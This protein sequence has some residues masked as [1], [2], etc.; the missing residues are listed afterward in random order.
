MKKDIKRAAEILRK[1]ISC[2]KIKYIKPL[3]QV[4]HKEHSKGLIFMFSEN[5]DGIFKNRAKIVLNE[6]TNPDKSR[7]TTQITEIRN[8]FK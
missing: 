4:I 3:H 6:G 7:I 5:F 8:K 1:E 2:I